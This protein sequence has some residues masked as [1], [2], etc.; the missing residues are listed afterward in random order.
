M[1][2]T[3]FFSK[4]MAGQKIQAVLADCLSKQAHQEFKIN[5]FMSFK[6]QEVLSYEGEQLCFDILNDYKKLLELV[7]IFMRGV[8]LRR[9]KFKKPDAMHRA[10]FIACLIY[11][12]NSFFSI[13]VDFFL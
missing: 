12:L 6:T 8:S 3:I 13:M 2:G 9:I 4:F 5:L 1:H 10:R 11:S 7:I